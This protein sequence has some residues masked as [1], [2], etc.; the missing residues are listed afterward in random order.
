[1]SK[2]RKTGFLAQAIVLICVLMSAAS[3]K[4]RDWQVGRV[5]DEALRQQL[6]AVGTV[7][8]TTTTGAASGFGVATT[9]G[10]A[11]TVGNTTTLHASTLASGSIT[12]ASQSR[13]YTA[14]QR[15]AVRSNEL[16]I[17]GD[18]YLYLIMDSRVRIPGAPL[19]NALSGRKHGCRFIVGEDI[20]FAQE[21]GD[22]W[23]VDPDGKT[24]KTSILR[25]E[26]K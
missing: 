16:L 4:E 24:C 8:N 9:M 5:V 19:M 20:R 6:I 2:T 23:V 12:M 22:L 26:V 7:T 17:V 11:N 13:S 3:G 15:V 25:Q 1:M 10:T 18:K 21:K 14:I